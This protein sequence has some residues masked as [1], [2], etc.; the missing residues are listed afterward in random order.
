VRDP[1]PSILPHGPLLEFLSKSS[2]GT[3]HGGLTKLFRSVQTPAIDT[4]LP[5]YTVAAMSRQ[6]KQLD[7][8]R[9]RLAA[10]DISDRAIDQQ[11]DHPRETLKEPMR[12][13]Q[14]N[15]ET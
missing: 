13:D 10:M 6:H 14:V 12:W 8:M 5:D 7:D 9:A 3:R 1:V 15:F 4:E 11:V 2:V